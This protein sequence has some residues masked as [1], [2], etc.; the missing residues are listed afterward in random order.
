MTE[1]VEFRKTYNI[2]IVNI[3]T[4]ELREGVIYH[5]NI[6]AFIKTLAVHGWLM[7][8]QWAL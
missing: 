2:S 7:A 4:G 8:E 3:K 6:S 5:H 1:Q